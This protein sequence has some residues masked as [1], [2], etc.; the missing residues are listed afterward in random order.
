MLALFCAGP[1]LRTTDFYS[2]CV[3][4]IMCSLRCLRCSVLAW[5][6]G[7]AAAEALEAWSRDAHGPINYR[8]VSEMTHARKRGHADFFC[9]AADSMILWPLTCCGTQVRN[10]VGERLYVA[11]SA[12]HAQLAGKLTGMFLEATEV[13]R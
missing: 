5:G 6:R 1:G 10:K 8:A 13:S 12:S 11:I 9:V 3:L 2:E 7:R 4:Y